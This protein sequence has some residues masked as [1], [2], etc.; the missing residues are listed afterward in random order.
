VKELVISDKEEQV[1]DNELLQLEKLIK[2][3]KL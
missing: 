2:E 3:L 1:L